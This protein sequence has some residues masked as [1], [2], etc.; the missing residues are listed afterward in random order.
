MSET[1]EREANNRRVFL[2]LEPE[3]CWHDWR[4]MGLGWGYRCGKNC[5][6]AGAYRIHPDYYSPTGC[7]ELIEAV[8]AKYHGFKISCPPSPS[9]SWMCSIWAGSP[10]D[11]SE[12]DRIV[13][14]LGDDLPTA[15]VNAVLALIDSLEGK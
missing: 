3:G 4:S 10:V 14:Q 11:Q 1:T 2:W 8:R 12:R 9:G 13:P 15:T 7:L 5:G 6:A